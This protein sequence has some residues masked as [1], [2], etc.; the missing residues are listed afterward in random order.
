[1]VFQQ[2]KELA[3][4]ANKN[5]TDYHVVYLGET[6]FP[7]GFGAIQKLIMISRSLIDEGA[8]VT[9]INRKGSFSP[10]QPV[11]LAIEGVFEA[12]QYVY[13]SGSIYKP[14]SFLT[15]NIAKLKGI[16]S[17][18]QYLIKLKKAQNLDAAIISCHHFGQTLLYRLYGYLF[19]IPL[20]YNHVELASAIVHRKGFFTK[21]N[22]YL[23][24]QYLIPSMDGAFP[25]SEVLV[26]DF[27]KVAPKKKQLKIPILCEFEKFDIQVSPPERDYFLYCG[28]LDYRELLDFILKAYDLLPE[29]NP[30]DLHFVLGGGTP[31]DLADLQQHVQSF[32]KGNQVKIFHN[33]RHADI[34]KHY[35][36]AKALLIPL[37]PTLQDAARFPHKIG[38]YLASG[39]P[40]ISTN[41]GEVAH[42]FTD[43]E[44]ALIADVYE[45]EPFAAK[46]QFVLDH[47][48]TAKKIGQKGLTFGRKAF[49]YSSYGAQIL[50]FLK[51]LK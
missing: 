6:G 3:K 49:S 17:E 43:Q 1:M 21:I 32:K 2:S 24:E 22:D 7:H 39:N 16:I 45:V 40:M 41:Y 42:Y 47:P 51:D 8:T 15:R 5:A 50:K 31:E 10:D 13:T 38:E 29:H 4:L 35:K 26:E 48:K 34:P 28:A 18:F 19:K 11:E 46:M 20:A 25:I 36:P 30:V 37:R 12:I 9:V 23:F 14:Q 27:R 33:V 44:N